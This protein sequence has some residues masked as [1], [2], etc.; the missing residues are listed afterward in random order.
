MLNIEFCYATENIQ[1]LKV[2][3]FSEGTPLGSALDFIFQQDWMLTHSLTLAAVE[4]RVGI[5]GIVSALDRILKAG[6]RIEIYQDLFQKPNESRR[7]RAKKSLTIKSKK[8]GQFL[9]LKQ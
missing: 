1:I 5:W 7:L 3:S 9:K 4:G 6:D 2:L 8:L